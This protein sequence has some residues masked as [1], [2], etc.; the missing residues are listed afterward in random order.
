MQPKPG[1]YKH[2]KGNEYKL[3]CVA[4]QTE[5]KEDLCIYQALYGEHKI[6]ARPI[7]MFMENV[8]VDGVKMPRFEWIREEV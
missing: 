5:T 4:W 1:I 7:G 3:L 6:F 8:V 2:Y